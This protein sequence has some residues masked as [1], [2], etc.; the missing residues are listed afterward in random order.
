MLSIYFAFIAF[1]ATIDIIFLLFN[2]T[3]F[4][5]VITALFLFFLAVQ[6]ALET[7]FRLFNFHLGLHFKML[8]FYVIED[9]IFVSQ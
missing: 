4:S 8:F 3:T 2:V 9:I 5:V 7:V 1:D 6:H